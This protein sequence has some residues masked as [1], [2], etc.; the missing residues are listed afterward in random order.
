VQHLSKK[1]RILIISFI[2]SFLLTPVSLAIN[3]EQTN[4]CVPDDIAG[5]QILDQRGWPLSFVSHVQF[6]ECVGKP[7]DL[8]AKEGINKV[9]YVH[10]LMNFVTFAVLSFVVLSISRMLFKSSPRNSNRI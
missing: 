9:N 1:F 3:R 6:T 2:I 10:L 7:G 8:G 5:S 4:I